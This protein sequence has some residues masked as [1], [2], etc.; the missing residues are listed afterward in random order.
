M[1]EYILF[2]GI[3]I[4]G[5]IISAFAQLMLKK[6]A[7]KKSTNNI[8][9]FLKKHNPKLTEKL[10]NSKN[11]LLVMLKHNKSLLAEY[12]NPYTILAYTIFIAATLL[13]I[14]SYKVVP[15][16]VA[17]ILG[18]TE[19]FF[20]AILSKIFLKEKI[21]FKKALGLLIIFVGII[22]YSI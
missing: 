7:H 4:S 16:S 19:Y 2:C 14:V 6:S 10:K 17:P 20:I 12:L 5:V 11:K 18:A 9:S 22:V 1:S 3:Y 13:T 15:L 8:F 21:N